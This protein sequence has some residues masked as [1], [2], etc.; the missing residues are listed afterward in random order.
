MAVEFQRLHE[1]DEVSAME[2]C[3]QQGW[4]DGLPVVPPTDRLVA[5]FLDEVGL[6][7]DEVLGE[8]A[9]RGVTLTAE[10]VA[11]NAVM[12]GCLPAYMPVVV[13]AIGAMT[14]PTFNLHATS[15]STGGAAHLLVVNGPVAKELEINAGSNVFGQGFRANATIGRSVQLAL[16]NICQAIPGKLDRSTMGTPG[17]FS[18]CI[19]ELEEFS[20]WEPLSVSRGFA[21]GENIVTAFATECPHYIF[22]YLSNEPVGILTSIAYKMA[23]F[24]N[25][26]DPHGPSENVIALCPEHVRTIGKWSK[27]D[28]QEFLFAHARRSAADLK[29][30]GKMLGSIEPGDE[31]LLVP[32]VDDPK[33]ISIVVVGGDAGGISCHVAGWA[34]G[35]MS[36]SVS[37]KIIV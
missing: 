28:V 6:S 21:E 34:G 20:P 4:T 35:R 2:Y 31:E 16:R 37:R 3:F 17:K 36:R 5:R 15:A 13:A 22:N 11:A 1:V 8:V 7:G 18:M 10:K 19:A 24:A 25:Y 9:P 23:A 33:L 32:L 29:R 12:A 14:D 27:T 30:A 26:H